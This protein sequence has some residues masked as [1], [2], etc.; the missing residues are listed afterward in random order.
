MRVEMR[1][2]R[3][4]QA[5]TGEP[6]PSTGGVIDLPDDEASALLDAGEAVRVTEPEKREASPPESGKHDKP[7]RKPAVEN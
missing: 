3:Q 4:G 6:W 1:V 7:S 2:W 5:S